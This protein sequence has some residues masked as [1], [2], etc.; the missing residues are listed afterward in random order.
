MKCRFTYEGK[1]FTFDQPLCQR[2]DGSCGP[3]YELAYKSGG[4]FIPGTISMS[5]MS[6]YHLV[7]RCLDATADVCVYEVSRIDTVE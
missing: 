5:P 7:Y 6:I 2:Q 4:M 1:T 3:P